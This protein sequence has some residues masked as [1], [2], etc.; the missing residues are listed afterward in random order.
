MVKYIFIVS[1][2]KTDAALEN[3]AHIHM[4]ICLYTFAQTYTHRIS[5]S[6]ELTLIKGLTGSVGRIF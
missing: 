4:L 5:V 1:H 6:R 2:Q 3:Q